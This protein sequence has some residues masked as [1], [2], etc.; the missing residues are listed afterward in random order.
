MNVIKTGIEGAIIIE[1][2]IFG[3]ARGYFFETFSQRDFCEQVLKK[4]YDTVT[5]K[6]VCKDNEL[7]FVQD[8]ESMSSYGVVRGLHY[9]KP[10]FAQAKL[11]RVVCGK[12]IDVAVDLRAG[13]P[14]FGKHVAVELSSENKRQFYIPCGFAHGFSVLSK[15][16]IFQYKCTNFYQPLSEGGI[17]WNDSLLDIDW[18]IPANKILA[19][20]KDSKQMSF[21]Q[22]SLAPVF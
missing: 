15:E 14:T 22:Y 17:M 16:A 4:Q 21:A 13:S 18:G 7:C 19:S 6:Y 9:Q 12:V 2:R 11:L 3:D 8:N 5:D 20:E 10:P 1:P